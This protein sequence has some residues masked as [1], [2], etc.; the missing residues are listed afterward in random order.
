M[1]NDIFAERV[2]SKSKGK[3]MG[4]SWDSNPSPSEYLSDALTIKPLGWTPLEA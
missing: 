4:S 2:R 3:N 1:N